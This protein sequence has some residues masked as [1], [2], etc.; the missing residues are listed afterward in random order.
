MQNKTLGEIFAESR[1]WEHV[2]ADLKRKVISVPSWSDLRKEYEPSLHEIMDRSQYPDRVGPDGRL[3]KVTRIPYNFQK[4]AVKRTT[5]LCFGLPAKVVFRPADDEK[6]KEVAKYLTNI[7]KRS[8]IDSINFERGT[9]LFASCE[10]ATLWYGVRTP[11]T[12]YGFS[13]P[14][15][16]RCRTFSPMN[17]DDIYP[18][19]DQHGDLIAL[20]FEYTENDGKNTVSYFDCYTAEKHYQWMNDGHG[21]EQ[22]QNPE[23]ISIGKIPGVYIWRPQPIW[24]GTTPIVSDIEKKMS[25]NGNYLDKNLKPLFCVFA[26]DDIPA[27]DDDYTGYRHDGEEQG[28]KSPEKE[29]RT[30]L[31]LPADAKANYITWPQAVE[32]LKFHITEARQSF[33]TQLQ[34]PDWSY[35]SMKSTPMSGE[36]RKQLFIDAQLKVTEESGRWIEAFDREINVL[37]S[38]LKQMLPGDYA[39]AID[40]LQFD[41]VITPFMIDDEKE[42][43]SNL[44]LANGNKP[45]ISQ[46]ESIA[47][48]GWSNDP[49][50]TLR[51]I[52]EEQM[53]DEMAM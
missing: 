7:L 28:E 9:Q 23:E 34:L 44:A 52:A 31:Q 15:K 53:V 16:L 24:E 47:R 17:G 22:T 10:S 46:K 14:I 29:D 11:T 37:K 27:R 32:S 12:A 19:Y 2:I 6:Q 4:L 1:P 30:I 50:K 36:S 45:M 26:D 13:S 42:R 48:L 5:Q 21:W 38:F 49:D 8:R 25:L 33:F 39:E 18:L 35:E 43:I 3:R 20:S 41:V 40:S 51:D